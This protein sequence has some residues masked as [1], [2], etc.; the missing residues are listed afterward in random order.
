[1]LGGE[2]IE[3]RLSQMTGI[4]A[5]FL[6]VLKSN[7]EH[8]LLSLNI[9]KQTGF[10]NLT[11]GKKL[12]FS[13]DFLL[14]DVVQVNDF[15]IDVKI[16]NNKG[17]EM[18]EGP[19][20]PKKRKHLQQD[21]DA[22]STNA[23]SLFSDYADDAFRAGHQFSDIHRL[24]G[25]VLESPALIPPQETEEGEIEE[26]DEAVGTLR[27]FPMMVIPPPPP[28]I[29]QTEECGGRGGKRVKQHARR[30]SGGLAPAIAQRDSI[31]LSDSGGAVSD[32]GGVGSEDAGEDFGQKQP[33]KSE[34]FDD[35]D[36][37]EEDI[38]DEEAL[39]LDY[40]DEESNASSH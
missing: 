7:L 1:M 3:D 31:S 11:N 14:S 37:E 18:E 12:R 39:L 32:P 21:G 19:T 5:E 9:D 28:T 34:D 26:D 35:D 40:D 2:D 38:E 29:E 16:Q 22:N 13:R 23:P 25:R 10:K 30:G 36:D 8:E 4:S 15:F 20:I 33:L 24:T 6:A 27:S 17:N